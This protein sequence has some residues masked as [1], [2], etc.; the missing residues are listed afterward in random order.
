[1]RRRPLSVR[2]SDG[3][4][5]GR[6]VG[7][8]AG[9]ALSSLTARMWKFE[10]DLQSPA[11][12]LGK[13]SGV[14]EVERRPLKHVHWA[15]TPARAPFPPARPSSIATSTR[16][17]P[18]SG[19]VQRETLGAN[20]ETPTY[21]TTPPPQGPRSIPGSHP[22][23]Q[24][25]PPPPNRISK[26]KEGRRTGSNRPSRVRLRHLRRLRYPKT[27][28][29]RF[30]TPVPLVLNGSEDTG[31]GMSTSLLPFERCGL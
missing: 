16:S 9:A 3:R 23:L 5:D 21:A 26:R 28:P 6:R 18:L 12:S 8:T 22:P 31:T 10:R 19:Q 13:G 11:P 30:P 14:P 29:V 20:K 25:S 17:I 24:S 7:A 2:G 15:R 1:M 27:V 4:R